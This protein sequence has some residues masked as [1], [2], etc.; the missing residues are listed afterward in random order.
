MPRMRRHERFSRR[1]LT[2]GATFV[3]LKD[4]A[5][6]MTK[7]IYAHHKKGFNATQAHLMI[8][9]FVCAIFAL[10]SDKENRFSINIGKLGTIYWYHRVGNNV[11]SYRQK[12]VVVAKDSDYLLLR[13][14]SWLKSAGKLRRLQ[15][16]IA[17]QFLTDEQIKAFGI[18]RTK[19]LKRKREKLKSEA[20][21]RARARIPKAVL[22]AQRAIKAKK[23]KDLKEAQRLLE[24]Q[25]SLPYDIR[26]LLQ[27]DLESTVVPPKKAN[28]TSE[29]NEYDQERLASL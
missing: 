5:R 11:Y 14:H 10:I 17:K 19:M 4:I 25:E 26:L 13:L 22:R 2:K 1:P 28:K 7:T 16:T 24:K 18:I 6:L 21:K 12:K 9:A 29:I 15:P 20:R 27:E 23:R 3:G 8:R